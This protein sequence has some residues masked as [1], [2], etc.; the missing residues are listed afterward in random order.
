[1]ARMTPVGETWSKPSTRATCGLEV[2]HSKALNLTMAVRQDR[3][4]RRS[5]VVRRRVAF[6]CRADS[7][8]LTGAIWW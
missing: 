6:R 8:L 5:G 2:T 3:P 4:F 7:P 1:M